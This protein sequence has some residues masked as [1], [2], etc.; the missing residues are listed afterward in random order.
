MLP[1]PVLQ[2]IMVVGNH[3][4]KLLL[5]IWP[6]LLLFVHGWY[7]GSLDGANTARL[8][9][10]VAGSLAQNSYLMNTAGLEN[11]LLTLMNMSHLIMA[12]SLENLRKIFKCCL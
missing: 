11:V 8:P 2:L 3:H 5:K 12:V 4:Y 7:G 1:L 6:G 9:G 10:C